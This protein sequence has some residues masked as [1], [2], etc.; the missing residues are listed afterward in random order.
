MIFMIFENIEFSAP[1]NPILAKN[2]G[3]EKLTSGIGHNK[4]FLEPTQK[5]IFG[6]PPNKKSSKMYFKIS[7]HFF[8]I[9]VLTYRWHKNRK[10]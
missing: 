9:S 3:P 2:R 5:A 1:K 8:K 4:G 6:S 7:T 10:K